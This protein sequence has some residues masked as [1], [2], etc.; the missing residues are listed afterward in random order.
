MIG[1]G[2]HIFV[3]S[4]FS[5]IFF[6]FFLASS[7][8]HVTFL[9]PCFVRTVTFSS[10]L[11]T[12]TGSPWPTKGPSCPI[13]KTY[14]TEYLPIF[15]FFYSP[16]GLIHRSCAKKPRGLAPHHRSA[17]PFRF[18]RGLTPSYRMASRYGHLIL[19]STKALGSVRRSAS[20][21]FAPPSSR[22]LHPTRFW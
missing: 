22:G 12:E 11:D 15:F 19:L 13:V 18:N 20:S 17:C 2:G 16:C 14:R 8:F 10:F 6:F 1:G 5:K 7:I 9:K 21:P 4:A 3:P